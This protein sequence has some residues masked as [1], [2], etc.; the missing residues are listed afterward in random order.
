MRLEEPI[1]LP[2]SRILNGWW[3][4]LASRRPRRLWYAHALIHRVEVL[5]EVAGLSAQ[6]QVYRSVLGILAAYRSS[7]VNE[8]V[9]RFGLP[10][11]VM[12]LVLHQLELEGLIIAGSLQPTS[13]GLQMLTR[14]DGALRRPQRR[15]FAFIDAPSPQFVSLTPAAS[16]PFS[17]P[18]GWRFDLAAIETAIAR[19]EEWKT[20][21]GFPLD[22]GR[23]LR[24][25]SEPT[26]MDSPRIP[27]DR[28]EQAFLVL[29][30]Q[31][32]GQVSAH[33]T[34]PESW[35]IGSEVVWSLP[36][37]G[38]LEELA[39]CEEAVW[40]AAWQLWARL[41]SLPAAEVDACRLERVAHR[42]CVHAPASLID[43]L[44]QGK[45]ES[46]EGKAWLLA[47]SG[48]IRAAACLELLPG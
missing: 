37:V 31:V 13:D 42:L 29:V 33:V 39:S 38:V 34:K 40:R 45:S 20:R 28:A 9:E 32:S 1:S 3:Y 47:G 16:L 2:G 12:T 23:L 35:S 48:R 11:G 8:L 14:S 21:H 10:A 6:E 41:R 19:P 30:E 43:R 5:V 22:V 17:P 36:D 44:R 24:P 15:T 46:L 25:P 7:T 27:V 4:E 26:T 18:S